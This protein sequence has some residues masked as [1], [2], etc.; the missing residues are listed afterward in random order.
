MCHV[1]TVIPANGSVEESYLRDILSEGPFYEGLYMNRTHAVDWSLGPSSRARTRTRI[2]IRSRW[3][4]PQ[5]DRIESDST[6]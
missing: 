3:A 5:M 6:E 2:R 1:L 4:N